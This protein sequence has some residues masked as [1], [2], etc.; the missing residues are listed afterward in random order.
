LTD[1]NVTP[2]LLDFCPIPDKFSKPVRQ[3]SADDGWI[4]DF[5]KGD[6]HEVVTA[7]PLPPSRCE[8][9]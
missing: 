6:V 2:K 9:C 4:Q 8:Q 5:C 3:L 1:S 7:L